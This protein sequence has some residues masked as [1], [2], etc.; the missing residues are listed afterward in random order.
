MSLRRRLLLTIAPLFIAGLLAVDVATYL[1]LQSFLVNRVDQQILSL[2]Q[3][4]EAVL[5][6]EDAGLF[7][8]GDQPTAMLPAGTFGEI[9][10]SNGEVVRRQDFPGPNGDDSLAALKLPRGLRPESF[11]TVAG[12]GDATPFRV[13]I[14]AVHAPGFTT[15]ALAV[16]LPLDEVSSTLSQLLVL[17]L[18]A[19]AAITLVILAAAWLIVHRGLRPLDRMGRAAGVAATDLSVRVEP[20]SSQTEVGRLG[21]AINGMLEQLENAFAERAANEQRLRHFVSDASHEL[22]TPLTSIRGY[23][24][25]MRRNPQMT[26]GDVRLATR[27]IEEEGRRMGVLVD[28]LLLLARLDQGRPLEHVAVDLDALAADACADARAA[29]PGRRITLRID[30]AVR[31]Q[32]DD[33]RLRQVLGNLLRNAL[34]HTPA[35]TPIEVT[36]AA[37]HGDAVVEVIDHGPG[38]HGAEPQHIFERFHRSDPAR[39]AD[40]GGSGLGLSIV[41][42]VVSAHGGRIDVRDTAGGGATFRITLPGAEVDASRPALP[43]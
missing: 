10:S 26:D 14:D 24:E 39:S 28:D 32:G 19:G 34:V 5:T 2:H 36:V 18:V 31:V 37:S 22:R 38:I 30:G 7:G 41:A 12:G 42:A 9:V 8:G 6:R 29:D 23:A 20:A 4:V 15:D 3:S 16:A 11:M 40:Q 35:S 17:E 43:G 25:L 1:A 33:M 21:L 27:R 13:Y